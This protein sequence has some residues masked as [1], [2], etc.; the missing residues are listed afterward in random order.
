MG[1]FVQRVSDDG[2]GELDAAG[3]D[4]WD[5]AGGEAGEQLA[6]CGQSKAGEVEAGFPINPPPVSIG[7]IFIPL[8]LNTG[9][10]PTNQHYSRAEPF[11]TSP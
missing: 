3:G 11:L 10:L 2:A 9:I 7:K 4:V 8:G 1:G 5:E 6:V